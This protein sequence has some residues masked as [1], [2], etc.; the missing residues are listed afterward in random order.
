MTV[1]SL[2]TPISTIA[3]AVT[4]RARVCATNERASGARPTWSTALLPTRRARYRRCCLRQYS[5]GNDDETTASRVSTKTLC[6]C[7]H[8]KT[9]SIDWRACNRCQYKT[10]TQ[11]VIERII[12]L[13]SRGSHGREFAALS[14]ISDFG[15]VSRPVTTLLGPV[16]M[17]CLCEN[18]EL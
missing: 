6:N 12:I 3:T 18:C 7:I 5:H 4:G 14:L 17:R 1:A 13:Y 15:I 8:L 2:A 10:Y 11:T 16:Q 9:V